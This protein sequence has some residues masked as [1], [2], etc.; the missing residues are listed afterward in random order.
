MKLLVTQI[1][2]AV[3]IPFN[4]SI[5]IFNSN[6]LCYFHLLLQTRHG[7]VSSISE[8]KHEIAHTSII[9]NNVSNPDATVLH[10]ILH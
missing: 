3:P 6:I 5:Q 4:H 9:Q 2:K 10:V 1:T 8:T 7:K